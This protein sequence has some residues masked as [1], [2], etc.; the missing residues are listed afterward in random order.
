MNFLD[1][2]PQIKKLDPSRAYD[3]IAAFP[4]QLADAW[5]QVTKS[6]SANHFSSCQGIF[7]AGMGGS[8]LG[9]RVIQSLFENELTIPFQVVT[10]YQLPAAVDHNSLVIIASYSGNTQETLSCLADAAK[11]RAQIFA[12]TTGG[13]VGEKINNGL[14]GVIFQ[15]LYNYLG[16]PKTAIGYAVGSLL[17]FLNQIGV[18]KIDFAAALGELKAVQKKFLVET[19][20]EKNPAKQLAEFLQ[21][22]IVVWVASEHLRGAAYTARNQINEIAHHFSLFFDLPEMDHHL[23][24]AFGQPE[25]AKSDLA[26]IFINS[27]RYHPRVQ[28]RYPITQKIIQEHQTKVISYPP[29]TTSQ[30]AQAWEIIQLGGFTSAYLS[31]LNHQDPG[32]EPWILKLKEALTAHEPK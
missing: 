29:Q 5:E 10:E 2:L 23:V 15:P 26:Y 25:A 8:A 17:G 30:L 22:K 21:N 11:R 1:D 14:P 18:V 3:S 28:S 24:E 19:P 9:G 32:P 31:F 20:T 16:Y 12:I 13:Q 27:H 7:L 4:Q 6:P